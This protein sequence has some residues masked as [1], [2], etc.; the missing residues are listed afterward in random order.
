MDK[1]RLL[2]IA[3]RNL[4]KARRSLEVNC[5][6]NGI[7]EEEINNLRDNVKFAE[8]VCNLIA[9]HVQNS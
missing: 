4:K 9:Y 1:D 7:T 2:Q 6:R 5:V 3:E 8:V